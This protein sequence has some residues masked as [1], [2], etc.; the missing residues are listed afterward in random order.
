MDGSRVRGEHIG[1][2]GCL[3]AAQM[4]IGGAQQGNF[5]QAGP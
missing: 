4:E 2:A 3:I 5:R 1:K